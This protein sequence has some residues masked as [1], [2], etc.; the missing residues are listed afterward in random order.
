[1]EI[2]GQPGSRRKVLKHHPEVGSGAEGG[3][4][5]NEGVVR[6]L[7]NRTGGIV[8]DGVGQIPQLPGLANHAL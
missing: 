2:N 4:T 3:S 7:E 6:V 1:M 8:N 5:K